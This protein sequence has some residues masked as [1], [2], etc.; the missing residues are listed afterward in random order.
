MDALV[1]IGLLISPSVWEHHYVLAIP[2][3]IW[4]VA[5][6]GYDRPWQVSIG[7]FLI[8]CLPTFDVFPFSFHRIT[9]LLM[10]L[11]AT[12]PQRLP[13]EAWLQNRKLFLRT[14][15]DKFSDFLN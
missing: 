15:L 8:F 4:A 12:S 3:A 1:A 5:T 10:L 11:D 14:H 7:T 13:I 9:G 6:Q 2:I